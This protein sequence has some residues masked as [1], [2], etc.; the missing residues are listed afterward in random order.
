MV[1]KAARPAVPGLPGPDLCAGSRLQMQQTDDSS[2]HIVNILI[3]PHHSAPLVTRS[4]THLYM[5]CTLTHMAAG[6]HIGLEPV[7]PDL[8]PYVSVLTSETHPLLLRQ[9]AGELSRF[10]VPGGFRTLGP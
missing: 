5:C 2:C 6:L 7:T 4:C 8:G 9:Q 10:Q 1:E 3:T